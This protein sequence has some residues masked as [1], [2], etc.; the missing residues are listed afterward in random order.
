MSASLPGFLSPPVLRRRHREPPSPAPTGCPLASHPSSPTQRTPTLFP[1][2][3]IYLRPGVLRP[4]RI[5]CTRKGRPKRQLRAV[6]TLRIWPPWAATVRVRRQERRR[7]TG[8]LRSLQPPPL[9]PP[10]GLRPR[11]HPF[12]DPAVHL[13]PLPGHGGRPGARPAAAQPPR[14]RGEEETLAPASQL[15]NLVLA[16]GCG[17]LAEKGSSGRS[18]KQDFAGAN[19]T[20][21]RCETGFARTGSQCACT[22]RGA[23]RGGADRIPANLELSREMRWR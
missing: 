3:P 5:F 16:R 7:Q 20:A 11:T 2:A 13:H 15:R 12:H 21:P 22:S 18:G 10:L 23:G 1:S 6:E 8:R 14:E 4:A 17:D 9:S 19:S